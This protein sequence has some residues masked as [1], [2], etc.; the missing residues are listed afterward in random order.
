MS[1]FYFRELDVYKKWCLQETEEE[2][3]DFKLFF[4]H[5]YWANYR[6]WNRTTVNVAAFPADFFFAKEFERISSL[7]S[8]NVQELWAR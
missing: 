3:V 1:N 6:C 7:F 2:K 4:I 8:A 5:F